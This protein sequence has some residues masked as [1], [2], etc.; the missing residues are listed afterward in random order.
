[1]RTTCGM[2]LREGQCLGQ[3]PASQDSVTK[4]AVCETEVT[5]PQEQRLRHAVVCEQSVVSFI[6]SLDVSMRPN[7]ILGVVASVIIF[8]LDPMLATRTR[9]HIGVELPKVTPLRAD[10]D[11]TTSIVFVPTMFR[12]GT[13]LTHAGPHLILNSSGSVVGGESKR[14]RGTLQTPTAFQ[15][16]AFQLTGVSDHLGSAV[17]QTSPTR[18]AFVGDVCLD[19][20]ATKSLSCD[21]D[22]IHTRQYTI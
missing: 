12:V 8:T 17:T 1:M 7:T 22:Q 2:Q 11:A 14:V 6:R 3:R 5:R 4:R 13:S 19:S 16:A 18:P 10:H 20:Q 21:I 15:C 9:P